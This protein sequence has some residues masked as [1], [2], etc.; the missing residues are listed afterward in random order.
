MKIRRVIIRIRDEK[1]KKAVK[2]ADK[3]DLVKAF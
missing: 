1:E 2:A 3:E